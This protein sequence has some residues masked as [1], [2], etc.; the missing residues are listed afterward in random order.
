MGKMKE[1]AYEINSDLVVKS[2]TRIEKIYRGVN[3]PTPDPE[4]FINDLIAD[5]MLWSEKNGVDVDKALEVA[6]GHYQSECATLADVAE[7]EFRDYYC[8]RTDA[9]CE[10]YTSDAPLPDHCEW[11]VI[12]HRCTPC[13]QDPPGV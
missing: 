5:A 3:D 11:G 9:K 12:L 1:L 6:S 10:G 2:L 13:L 8:E 4:S 7:C